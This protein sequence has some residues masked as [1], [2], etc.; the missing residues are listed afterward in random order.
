MAD[1]VTAAAEARVAA[2]EV[3]GAVEVEVAVGVAGAEIAAAATAVEAIA[4]EDGGN[5]QDV[6]Q[7]NRCHI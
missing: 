6:A 5:Q 7:R 2:A 1:S 4:A 3:T